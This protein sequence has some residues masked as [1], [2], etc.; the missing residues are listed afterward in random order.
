MK[1][2]AITNLD[3]YT[4]HLKTNKTLT[5]VVDSDNLMNFELL[6]IFSD[7]IPTTCHTK[8]KYLNRLDNKPI[9][10]KNT[11]LLETVSNAG[12]TLHIYHIGPG[13][14]GDASGVTNTFSL[15]PNAIFM[16][17]YGWWSFTSPEPVITNYNARSIVNYLYLAKTL[18]EY[19]RKDGRAVPISV[20]QLNGG[21]IP[22]TGDISTYPMHYMPSEVRNKFPHL[23]GE[24]NTN[25]TNKTVYQNTSQFV[26]YI[27]GEPG[28]KEDY[29]NSPLKT[30]IAPLDYLN[31]NASTDISNTD[32]NSALN[33]FD[34]QSNKIELLKTCNINSILWGSDHAY[35]IA[36]FKIVQDGY[37]YG[38][39][40][41]L[42]ERIKKYQT[43]LSGIRMGG[44]TNLPADKDLCYNLLDK[45]SFI[46]DSVAIYTAQTK[47]EIS[48]KPMTQSTFRLFIYQGIFQLFT[49]LEV[50]NNT[51]IDK[52]VKPYIANYIFNGS[53]D[54]QEPDTLNAT[55]QYEYLT[56]TIFLL[57]YCCIRIELFGEKHYPDDPIYGDICISPDFYNTFS[58]PG[59]WKD[60][61]H[62]WKKST[63]FNDQLFNTDPHLQ[64]MA[65]K[66]CSFYKQYIQLCS[67]NGCT[68][69]HNCAQWNPPTGSEGKECDNCSNDKDLN[70]QNKKI[71]D[72]FDKLSD[73][74]RQ[75]SNW[76][77]FHTIINMENNCI[78]SVNA[79]IGFFLNTCGKHVNAGWD[80]GWK[81][82]RENTGEWANNS[83]TTN[84]FMKNLPQLKKVDNDI[85][86]RD[87]WHNKQG[88]G[89]ADNTLYYL[90]H[91]VYGDT[92][93]VKVM[94]SPPIFDAATV[95]QA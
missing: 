7:H 44:F 33:I 59:L 37:K 38:A 82:N 89:I 15:A 13:L 72:H 92:E 77:K 6:G 85:I 78:K 20:F 86:D 68:D 95:P 47:Q 5:I 90:R 35:T 67:Y 49:D 94:S 19:S 9:Q 25:N 23:S 42:F 52:H 84:D 53:A 39:S 36:P 56:N 48:T 29:S 24:Y 70:T 14:Y 30:D 3:T 27:F 34:W 57:A 55:F 62:S 10:F 45:K 43:E 64:Q 40:W 83:Y 22:I 79:L 65:L 46:N 71:I 93:S 88:A 41:V 74:I 81:F 58:D 28:L 12:K 4:S 91:N 51:N 2:Q 11:Y 50:L 21:N 69:C 26:T 8:I 76:A 61:Q 73:W 87:G 75:E 54:G 1:L 60:V 66:I 16:D 31:S 80:I 18:S 63:L 17:T 32:F